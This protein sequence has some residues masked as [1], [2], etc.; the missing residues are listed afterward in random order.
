MQ[1]LGRCSGKSPG[2]FLNHFVTFGGHL[3]FLCL[4]SLSVIR[5][6]VLQNVSEKTRG[7]LIQCCSADQ[8][9]AQHLLNMKQPPPP[10]TTKA[11]CLLWLCWFVF[12]HTV[13]VT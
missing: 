5:A 13:H 12:L 9:G 3:V 1:I 4:S 11:C 2:L 7:E 6:V 8:S 10:Q